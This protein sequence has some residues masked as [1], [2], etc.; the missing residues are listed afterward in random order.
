[1]NEEK[2]YSKLVWRAIR[3]RSLLSFGSAQLPDIRSSIGPRFYPGLQK[4]WNVGINVLLEAGIGILTGGR[5]LGKG[6][7]GADGIPRTRKHHVCLTS[8]GLSRWRERLMASYP[9]LVI[10]L[11]PDRDT[12]HTILQSFPGSQ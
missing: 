11:E 1:M 5:S 3:R 10:L 8:I 9:K 6:Q 7:V 2:G 4:W 12:A